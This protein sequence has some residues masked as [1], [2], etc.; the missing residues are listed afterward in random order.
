MQLTGQPHQLPCPQCAAPMAH[1]NLASHRSA[2]V[3]VD[4]CAPCRLVW[5]DRLESVQLAGLGWIALLR[6]LQEPQ[7][8]SAPLPAPPAAKLACPVCR[9]TLKPVQ[10]STRFGRFP[11]LE[12]PSCG[13][14]LHSHAGVLAERGL[15]RP[16]LPADRRVLQDERRALCCLN[17]GAPAEGREEA[18]RYCESP[19]LM[20]DLPRLTQALR[21]GPG[22]DPQTGERQRP[23]ALWAW[24]CHG[25]GAALDP[26]RHTACT[27]CGHAVLAPSLLDLTPLL[28]KVEAEWRADIAA[29]AARRQSQTASALRPN[30][31][32]RDWRDTTMA[33]ML[34][35]LRGDADD[36]APTGAA[37]LTVLSGIFLFLL[38]RWWLGG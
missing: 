36:D 12:C 30:Q 5:F 34:E 33:R 19:L 38:L 2:S 21:L 6:E 22:R 26:S 8:P 17:C 9:V 35:Q 10:N 7:G 1:L 24:A 11:A 23:A 13:G 37:L 29:R 16:L 28:D 14:H 3:P 27:Q 31:R 4:H 32:T 15:V 18:C 25:C 20:L